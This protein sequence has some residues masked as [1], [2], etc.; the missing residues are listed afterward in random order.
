MSRRIR[1]HGMATLVGLG[2]SCCA[3]HPAGGERAGLPRAPALER[4]TVL[5][6]RYLPPSGGGM[7]AS[8]LD[9]LG[10][11][12]GAQPSGT[13]VIVRADDGQT[14]SIVQTRPGELA[15]G[16]RVAIQYGEATRLLPVEPG[17]PP[18]AAALP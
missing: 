6:T 11:R 17:P 13:E 16:E 15:R 3:G 12:A 5:V 10:T 4:G 2:V 18:D 7:P 8:I 1:L 9:A 14:I